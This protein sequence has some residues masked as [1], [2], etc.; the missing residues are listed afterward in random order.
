MKSERM[1]EWGVDGG[2]AQYPLLDALRESRSRRF[3]VG[4]RIPSGP[5]AFESRHEP[6]PLTE[7]E[8]AALV[9]AACGVTGYALA[10]LSY[11]RGQGGGIRTTDTTWRS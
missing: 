8:E 1:G 10:D 2:L 11:G 7:D 5:F 9:F 4:M 3:G 6:L